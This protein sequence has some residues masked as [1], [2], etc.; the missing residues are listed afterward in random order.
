M[1]LPA[2]SPADTR[3]LV[4]ILLL[5]P[6]LMGPPYRN[7]GREDE[8]ARAGIARISPPISCGTRR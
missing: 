2:W 7:L 4:L 8:S 5:V 6:V 1:A 3:A